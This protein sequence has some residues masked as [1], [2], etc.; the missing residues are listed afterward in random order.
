MLGKFIKSNLHPDSITFKVLRKFYNS[1]IPPS[2]SQESFLDYYSS[3]KPQA[4][5]IEIGANDGKSNDPIHK[6]ILNG[7][8]KGILVEPVE[9][10]FNRLKENYKSV[11]Q[12]LKFLNVAIGKSDGYSTFYA[13]KES[14][15]GNVPHW[16]THL[17]SFD[18]EVILKHKNV[19]PNIAEL[20]EEKKVETKTFPSIMQSNYF[21]RFDLL[22]IDTEGFDYEILKMVDWAIFKPEVIIYEH[23]HLSKSDHKNSI[24]LLKQNNYNVF[25]SGGDTMAIKPEILKGFL[26]NNKEGVFN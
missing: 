1:W 5:F 7:N 3:I 8:W 12:N 26:K 21:P 13:I 2:I 24:A 4:Y 18:K 20:I 22:Q 19:I 16:Y 6:H 11:E 14:E 23:R 17:G 25:L 10:I 15:S 9:N